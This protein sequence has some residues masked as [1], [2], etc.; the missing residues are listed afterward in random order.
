M[1]RLP[2]VLG[3]DASV[4]AACLGTRELRARGEQGEKGKPLLKIA[5]FERNG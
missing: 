3:G 1:L 5:I 4:G 2:G